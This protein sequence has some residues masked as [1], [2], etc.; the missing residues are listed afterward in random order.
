VQAGQSEVRVR[1]FPN[2]TCD[3]FTAVMLE[4]A[5]GKRRMIHLDVITGHADLKTEDQIAQMKK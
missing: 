3:E 4:P 1:F 2:G 5:S